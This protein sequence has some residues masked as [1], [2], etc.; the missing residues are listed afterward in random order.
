MKITRVR[1]YAGTGDA[2]MRQS[3]VPGLF[4]QSTNVVVVETDAGISG[5]GQGGARDTMEQCAAAVIGMD[6]SRTEQ[7]WQ[8]LYRATLY[9]AGREKLHAVGALDVALW[10]IK[11]KALGVPLYQL[12][13]GLGRDHVECYVTGYPDKGGIK[14]SAAACVAEGYR[15]YRCDPANGEPFDR[16]E[17]VQRTYQICRDAREGAGKDGGWKILFHTPSDPPDAVRL[18]QMIE[19]LGAYFVEDLVRSENPEV[20]RTLRQQVK[21]PIAVGEQFGGRWDINTLVEGQLI[22]YSRATVP[23]VGGITEFLKIAA[24]CETHYIGLIPHFT[25]PISEAALVHLCVAFS[26]RR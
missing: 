2:A 26:A 5:I 4:N 19:G 18:C 22:D 9:P 8:I 13:G 3:K 21:V 1:Y 15:A 12:F 10:D 23:N 14:A 16:F 24:L 6:P 25:G 17:A 7:I 11:A 20:Y